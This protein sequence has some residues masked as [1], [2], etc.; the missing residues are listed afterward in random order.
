MSNSTSRQAVPS[1]VSK[2][3][4]LS[5]KQTDKSVDLTNGLVRLM[6][7]ESILQDTVK[8]EIVFADTGNSIDDK[9]V[10]EGLPLVGTEDVE[11]EFKDNNDTTL[12]INLNVNKV[13]PVNEESTSSMVRLDLVS[14]EFLRNEGGS[15]RLNVRFDGKISD[16][17]RRI[18]TDFLKTEKKLDIEETSNNYNFIGNNRKPYYV[19]NWLSKASIPTVAGEKGKTGGFFFFETSEGFK[20]KSID[21][22]FKQ[23]QKKSLIYNLTTDL[24]AGYDTKVLDFQGDNLIRS[25]EKLKIGAYGTRLVVFDPFNCFYEVIEQTANDSKDGTELAAKELPKLNDKFESDSKFTRT[26]YRLIDTGTLPSGTT[27]Q[28]IDK[29]TEQNFELQKIMNQ[30]IRRYN[31]LFTGMQTVTIPGDFSLHAGD[32]LFLD[33]PGL[34][35][36]KEDKLNKEYGG[37]YIIADLCHYISPEETYTKLNLVRDSFGRKGNHTTNIPL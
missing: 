25:Q 32:T 21:G 17:I 19:L 33:T 29:S 7:Y 8:S 30:T 28:Q 16:H 4:V 23:K 1:T 10:L 2:L 15:S 18:L 11:L 3:K 13:T 12:K 9:S 31:Q 6:Y 24:P 22:L 36:K 5:N 14:E 35:P 20:F 34:R 26:T 27:Q 37:L